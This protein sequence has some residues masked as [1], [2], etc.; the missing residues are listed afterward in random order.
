M[1]IYRRPLVRTITIYRIETNNFRQPQKVS[2]W[3][4]Q[5]QITTTSLHIIFLSFKKIDITIRKITDSKFFFLLIHHSLPRKNSSSIMM[6]HGGET[7]K[8]IRRYI[9]NWCNESN[10]CKYVI[11]S[12][13]RKRLA[14][15]ESGV[16]ANG[17]FSTKN[18]ETSRSDRTRNAGCKCNA[19]AWHCALQRTY[20][21]QRPRLRIPEIHIHA[22]VFEY[23]LR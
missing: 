2:N 20:N 14:E 21:A 12:T 13:S 22:K 9:K 19:R 10:V 6:I 17:E 18:D 3:K 23:L 8:I 1:S 16:E 7:K 11:R 15:R 5:K 4:F